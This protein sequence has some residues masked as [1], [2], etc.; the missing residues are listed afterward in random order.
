M[1]YTV[2]INNYKL[3]DTPKDIKKIKSSFRRGE[4]LPGVFTEELL[5][6]T[7][8]GDGY[9]VLKTLQQDLF[10]CEIPVVLLES[11]IRNLHTLQ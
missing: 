3:R 4:N 10:N 1:I 9:C 5:E 8:V 11:G 6:I 7:M 2:V